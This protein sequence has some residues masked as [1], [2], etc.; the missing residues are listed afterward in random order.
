MLDVEKESKAREK[1][2][3]EWRGPVPTAAATVSS[4]S[5]VHFSTDSRQTGDPASQ[6]KGLQ[7]EARA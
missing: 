4:R 2:R 3:R 5:R 6:A 1:E 7:A